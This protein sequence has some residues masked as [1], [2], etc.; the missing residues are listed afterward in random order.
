[1]ALE[2]TAETT[3]RDLLTTH[4]AAAGVLLRHGMCADCQQSPPPVPL[5]HFAF[6]HCG[7][8][9]DG[10]IREIQAALDGQAAAEGA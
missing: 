7:G 5:G 6:K 3:V 2:L 1:M 4:P 9:L 10:L 8:D